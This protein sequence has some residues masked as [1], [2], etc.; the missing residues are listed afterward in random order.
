[1]KKCLFALVLLGLLPMSYAYG[2]DEYRSTSSQYTTTRPAKTY[3]KTSTVRKTG[4]YHNTINNNF[5]YGQP[6]TETRVVKSE[7]VYRE[8]EEVEY[9]PR[10]VAKKQYVERKQVEYSSQER[11]YFLAHPF[12][13]PLKGSFGSVTDVAYAKNS[14]KFDILN[15]RFEDRDPDRLL[16]T[17]GVGGPD[18]GGKAEGSQILVKEDFSFG[19]SDNLALV[20]M[21]QYDKTKVKFKDWYDNTR[22]ADG[23]A[24]SSSTDSGVR[25]FGIGLQD[26]FIDNEDWIATFTGYFQ[27]QKD[28]ANSF[29]FNAKAGYKLNRTTLYGLIGIGYFNLIDGDIYGI[30]A[31]DPS[32]DW[33]WLSYKTDVKDIFQIE[34]GLGAFSVLN[35]YAYLGAEMIYGHYDWHNQLSAKGLIGFQPYDSFALTFYGSMSLYDSAKN[36]IRQ[37][38]H[39]DVNPD[40]ASYAG[41]SSKLIY[42]TGDYKIKSYNE[43]KV[44]VQAILYF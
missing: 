13:Q 39:N 17:V 36:K 32:G 24:N 27:H 1:M 42:E 5:Y 18:G 19:L 29:V 9:E 34:G 16:D 2:Y 35:K 33:L 31:E 8:Y 15:T 4:G 20:L 7:P 37:Y 11:K 28:T 3:K 14:F 26:R 10:T 21:A 30:A 44:G 43:W 6:A 23:M 40:S 38:F 41:L 12:F 22:I 25:V